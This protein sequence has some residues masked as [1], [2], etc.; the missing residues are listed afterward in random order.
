MGNSRTLFLFLIVREEIM[1]RIFL[2]DMD[3]VLL[4]FLLLADLERDEITYITYEGKEKILEKLPGKKIILEKSKMYAKNP[5]FNRFKMASYIKE[6][7]RELSSLLEDV[8]NGRAKIFGM[9]NLEL[10]RRVFYREEISVIEEGTLNYMPYKAAP[11]GLK[12][13]VQD[14][15]SLIYGLG[16]RKVLMGYGD[17]VAKVYLTDSLCDK[18]PHGLEKK[19]EIIN[20]K[21]LWKRKS[22]REKELIKEV[23]GFNSEIFEKVKGE[24][25]MLFTQ[26]MSEDGIVSE[27]R[28]IELYSKVIAK[29]SGKSIIIKSHP[30]EKTDY[31]SY[32]P[33]CYVMKERYP[34]ELLGVMGIELERVV[35]LFST[36]VFGFGKDVAIDFYGSEVDDKLFERFGSCDNI[37]VRNS[38]L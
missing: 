23:F 27:E 30:R 15:I 20:L 38:Y 11:S 19:A 26:P 5:I 8:K 22:E 25:I 12:G 37:M 13:M 6:L 24:S 1:K 16:E 35:T 36:A 31:S 14:M 18:I 2:Y 3:R 29:Y 10:G 28:K 34:V 33:N 7:R 4:I 32:F 17:K 21:N 9:D